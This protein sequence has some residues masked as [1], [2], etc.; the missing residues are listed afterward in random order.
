LALPSVTP[1]RFLRALCTTAVLAA[2]TPD[3]AAQPP[4]KVSTDSLVRA[5]RARAAAGDTAAALELLE[6]ATALSPRDA[7]ALYWRGVVLMRTSE[8]GLA[9]TR[10]RIIAGRLLNRAADVD[11]T[12]ARYLVE[13]G[14]LRL[15][16]P[17]LRAEAE[18]TFRKA[19]ALAEASNDSV[20]VAAAA[21]ELGEVKRRRYLTGRDRYIYTSSNT[22]NPR[23]SRRLHYTREFLE[24][25]ARP[26]QGA[27]DVDRLDAEEFFRRALRA[28][29]DDTGSLI[30]LLDL[31]Y[32]Q[33]RYDEMLSQLHRRP[34]SA[35]TSARL[36][37]AAGLAHVRLRQLAD[38]EREFSVALARLPERDRQELLNIGRILRVGDSVRVAGL[39]AEERARTEGAYWEAA[40][41]L[42][43][44]PENEARLEY[45]ARMAYADLHYSDDDTHQPGWRTD[46]AVILARYGEPPVIATFAPQNYADAGDALGRII[47]VWF[48]PRSEVEFV[49]T[50]PPA[51]NYATFAGNYRDFAEERRELSPFMLDNLPVAMAVD[52]I[53]VQ[54]SRFRGDGARQTE[55]VV[56]SA[57]P[58]R[59]LYRNA[60]MDRSTLALELRAGAAGALSLRAR[61]TVRVALPSRDPVRRVWSLTLPDAMPV[62]ARLEAVD[63]DVD[64]A[65]ARAQVDL[66]PLRVDSSALSASDLMLVERVDAPAVVTRW[67]QLGLK[68][69]G[70]LRIAQ[71]DTFGMYW[72]LYGLRPT[73][74][75]RVQYDVKVTVTVLEIDRGPDGVARF[76]GGV[77]DLV[78]LTAEGEDRLSLNFSRNEA[79]RD[80]NRHAELIT[81][82]L[83]TSPAG[84]Y[85]LTVT[86]TERASKRSTTVN[87]DFFI[88]R[89]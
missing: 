73:P 1:F 81:L 77:A 18:R 5:G 46:R 38:A 65:A 23:A 63:P 32:D 88:A 45:L 82:G 51:F 53:P 57:I 6:R 2:W 47:T 52:T 27:G 24:S 29:P 66:P 37:L 60:P 20:Q 49:F 16:T 64:A 74:D 67:Q 9:D 22:F 56:A 34:A 17:I 83:G 59:R 31:L 26:V 44:T 33:G 50:G 19:L 48:Y 61:D 71:R 69:L 40:D 28:R 8:L 12:N 35:D 42:L 30:A 87:R 7:E 79:A 86:I 70:D 75:G 10:Q 54:S 58:L 62:R 39:P 85:R 41:P 84:R 72:E 36:H 80:A 76:F 15:K 13:L 89:E 78:G 3:L 11:P 43:S 25:L 14:R 4:A 55:L 68:P 21:R